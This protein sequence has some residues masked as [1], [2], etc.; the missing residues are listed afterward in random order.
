MGERWKNH[1]LPIT[2]YQLPITNSP[3]PITDSPFPI[4]VFIVTPIAIDLVADR[5]LRIF[6]GLE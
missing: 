4:P 2:N 1:R 5:I 6:P 3:G